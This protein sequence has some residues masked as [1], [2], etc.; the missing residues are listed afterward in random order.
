MVV[1]IVG[2]VIALTKAFSGRDPL[3]MAVFVWAYFGILY[4]HLS[5]GGFGAEHLEVVVALTV[6][7]PVLITS[8]VQLVREHEQVAALGKSLK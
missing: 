1:L 6:L 5:E 8:L 4:K 7:I 2:A 3:Y